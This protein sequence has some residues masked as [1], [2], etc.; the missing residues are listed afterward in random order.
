M[1]SPAIY[2]F[3]D[4]IKYTLK[5][6][7]KLRQWLAYIIDNEK[8]KPGFINI[9]FCND[10]FLH[11]LNLQ[12]LKHDTLTDI[13]TFDLSEE[14]DMVEGDIYISFDRARENAKKFKQELGIE[15]NRLM[16][17]GLLH[18]MGYS[19]KTKVQK[20]MMTEKQEYYLTLHP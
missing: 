20:K 8:Y 16:V 5:K 19:D 12:Y 14:D 18:L 6:K 4:D 11:E 2:F 10:E 1:S 3:N 9:I 7:K 13:I 15:L 17:H